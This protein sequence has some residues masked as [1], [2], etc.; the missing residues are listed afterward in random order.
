MT[1]IIVCGCF[2]RL[3]SA[4][5]KLAGQNGE[6]EIAAG[7]NETFLTGG[8]SYIID[9]PIFN[10]IGECNVLADVVIVCLSPHEIQ[11]VLATTQYCV[12]KRIPMILCTT[13]LPD[14][15]TEKIKKAS[16]K[17]PVLVSAN[18]SLGIN[19]LSHLLEKAAKLLYDA[20]FDIE[21]IERHHNQKLDAPS[22]TAYVLAEAANQTL[23]GGMKYVNDRSPHK[24]KRERNEIG[25]H[26]LRGGTITGE[27]TVV[28]AGHDEVIELTHAAYS[29]EV[30]A[31]GA[32]KA[33]R[34]I[35]VK[36]A[37]LYTMRDLI[38]TP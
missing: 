10:E 17:I 6:A 31:V 2:G 28:F 22:G 34:F 3:G 29:R 21:I 35:Q 5:C 14:D 33:A 13:A 38:D 37:G 4:I 7:V 23:G 25:L 8:G 11:A 32:L 16:E 15:V 1:K 9:F 20:G 30:F 36:S 27:H 26:A 18:L 19:L 12:E 24:A